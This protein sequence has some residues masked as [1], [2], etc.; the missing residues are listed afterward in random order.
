MASGYLC[1]VLHWHLPFVRHP[2]H[3][4]FLEEDWLFEAISETYIPLLSVFERLEAEGV[5]FRLTISVS[6]T[7]A[8]MLRDGFLQYRYLSHL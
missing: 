1:F 4:R 7:L 2:E 8:E 3:P 6:P 5:P